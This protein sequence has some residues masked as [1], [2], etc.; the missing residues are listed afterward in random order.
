MQ[1]TFDSNAQGTHLIC[2]ELISL[3]ICGGNEGGGQQRQEA[4]GSLSR[5]G[6]AVQDQLGQCWRSSG[7]GLQ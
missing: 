7:I 2:Q 4:I 6:K 5:L 3:R 1:T